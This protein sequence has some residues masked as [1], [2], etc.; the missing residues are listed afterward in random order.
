[1]RAFWYVLTRFA[2]WLL[3]VLLFSLVVLWVRR[4]IRRWMSPTSATAQ[5]SS[6]SRSEVLVQD[7]VCGRYIPI[8]SA[9]QAVR[10]NERVYFCSRACAER[11]ITGQYTPMVRADQRESPRDPGVSEIHR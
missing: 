3:A 11:F 10:K 2:R 1:M 8:S 5:Q 4:W 9:V 6:R 7:P